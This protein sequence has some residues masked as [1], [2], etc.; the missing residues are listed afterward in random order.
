[1]IPSDGSEMLTRADHAEAIVLRIERPFLREGEPSSSLRDALFREAESADRPVVLDLSVVEFL[2]SAALGWLITLRRRLRDRGRSFGPPCRR[3][4]F[5]VFP[6]AAA[7]LDA[8]RQGESD[9]LLLC[10]VR[11]GVREIFVVC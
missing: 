5:A 6:D 3:G 10:G 7:A 4:L 8:I 1:M 11:P 9:P 2:T